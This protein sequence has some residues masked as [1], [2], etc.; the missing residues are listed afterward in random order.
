MVEGSTVVSFTPK[1]RFG[2]QQGSAGSELSM[3]GGWC[4]RE[5]DLTG[6][7]FGVAPLP[8]STLLTCHVPGA[9]SL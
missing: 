5:N 2:N 1:W 3:G 4:T 7:S 8:L 9:L 6:I